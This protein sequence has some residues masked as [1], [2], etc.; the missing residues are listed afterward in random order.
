MVTSNSF[1]QMTLIFTW[2]IHIPSHLSMVSKFHWSC[3]LISSV[4][5][6]CSRRSQTQTRKFKTTDSFL[7]K[8]CTYGSIKKEIFLVQFDRDLFSAVGFFLRW[9]LLFLEER[10]ICFGLLVSLSLLLKLCFATL[11]GSVGK[12]RC[13]SKRSPQNVVL[14]RFLLLPFKKPDKLIRSQWLCAPLNVKL[15]L[16]KNIFTMEFWVT[17]K[18]SKGVI[19]TDVS[20]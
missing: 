1:E 10:C 16:M 8:L 19:E 13:R 5:L 9:W 7:H 17:E 20:F 2:M 12:V 11:L 18:N 14:A 6:K 3:R 4:Q 15:L